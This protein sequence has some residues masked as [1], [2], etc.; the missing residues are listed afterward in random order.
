M[1]QRQQGMAVSCCW[2]SKRRFG[3][4]EVGLV[5]Q[6]GVAGSRRG[7]ECQRPGTH[8]RVLGR[9]WWDLM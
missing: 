2:S 1:A 5:R 6:T 4:W 7:L 3:E 9:E 8:E